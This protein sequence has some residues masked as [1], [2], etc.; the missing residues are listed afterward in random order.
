MDTENKANHGASNM[1]TTTKFHA[2]TITTVTTYNDPQDA[3]ASESYHTATD[4][5]HTLRSSSLNIL[6]YKIEHRMFL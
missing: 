6:K 4:G 5:V 1:T 3:I 2:F